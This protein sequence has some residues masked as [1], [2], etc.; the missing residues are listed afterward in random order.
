MQEK[1]KSENCFALRKSAAA[2]Q[3]TS[4]PPHAW[5]RPLNQHNTRLENHHHTIEGATVI[6]TPPSGRHLPS[7]KLCGI[8]L[9]ASLWRLLRPPHP[10]PVC[11]LPAR[12]S[13][14]R[15]RCVVLSQPHDGLAIDMQL[16]APGW[17]L[18]DIPVSE[19]VHRGGFV[20]DGAPGP[21]FDCAERKLA[22][23]TPD[24]GLHN[25]ETGVGGTGQRAGREVQLR[26]S[27]RGRKSHDCAHPGV[28][29]PDPDDRAKPPGDPGRQ[30]RMSPSGDLSTPLSG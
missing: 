2:Y 16:Q 24:L 28:I 19:N 18:N 20:S 11:G 4:A 15:I 30:T 21:V 23:M 9:L 25:D 26:D 29:T 22:G 6:Q 13:R 27:L 3:D 14:P 1:R 10:A 5:G 17:A 7:Q 8:T 12:V